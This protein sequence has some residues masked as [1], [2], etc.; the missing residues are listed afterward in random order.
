MKTATSAT[1][2]EHLQS[3]FA[4]HGLPELLATDNGAT[5]TSSECK[6]LLSLNGIQHV[7]SAP[8]HPATNG[9]AERTVQT[10]K[11]FLKKPS[12][13][14]LEARLSRFLL[15]YSELEKV[16]KDH[17]KPKPLIIAERFKFHRQNQ[18]EGETVAQY[19]AK[20]ALPHP[21]LQECRLQNCR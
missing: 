11:E 1:T 21:P 6:E 13:E 5:F 3:I 10:V 4:T 7:I 9:Q 17:L 8:Y 12:S 20:A 16:M 14:P 15:Q 19:L 18:R 2:I